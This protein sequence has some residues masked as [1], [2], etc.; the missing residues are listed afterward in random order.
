MV[1]RSSEPAV[2]VPTTAIVR[3]AGLE[4]VIGIEAGKAVEKRVRTGRRAGDR[5]EIVDG[6]AAGEPVVLNP[7]N[8]VGGQPVKVA[9]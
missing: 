1:T 3:F 4:K 5:I 2:F 6:V 8:L 9:P 7:G